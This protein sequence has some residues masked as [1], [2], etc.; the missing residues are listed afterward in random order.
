MTGADPDYENVPGGRRDTERLTEVLAQETRRQEHLTRTP[1]RVA[2]NLGN[3][4]ARWLRE[5]RGRPLDGR[6]TLILV[7]S[8]LS[9]YCPED[10]TL[11]EVANLFTIRRGHVANAGAPAEYRLLGAPGWFTHYA[12][13]TV[14][15]RHLLRPRG[16]ETL[17]REITTAL[18]VS[19]LDEATIETLLSLWE[20]DCRSEYLDL[21][22]ALHAAENLVDLERRDEDRRGPRRDPPRTGHRPGTLEVPGPIPAVTRADLARSSRSVVARLPR[23]VP[24]GD[25]RTVVGGC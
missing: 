24:S 2:A 14:E 1:V 5:H 12:P 17:R 19:T 20:P 4:E 7:L 3:L 10:P 6:E 21:A 9:E 22:S 15:I 16:G 25:G 18:D 13:T 11:R 8:P 23:D